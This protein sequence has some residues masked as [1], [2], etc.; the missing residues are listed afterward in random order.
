MKRK[1]KMKLIKIKQKKIENVLLHVSHNWIIDAYHCAD[2]K[3][4][5]IAYQPL[6]LS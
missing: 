4:E 5:V 1:K 6:A 3:S 2:E